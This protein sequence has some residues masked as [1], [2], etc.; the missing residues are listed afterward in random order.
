MGFDPCE[1]VVEFRG[2]GREETGLG[3]RKRGGREELEMLGCVNSL[4]I[5]QHRGQ[6]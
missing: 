2:Q 4:Y 5:Y 1:E 3:G 6:S